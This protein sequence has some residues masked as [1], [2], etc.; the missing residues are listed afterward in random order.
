M[1]LF[2]FV[3]SSEHIIAQNYEAIYGSTG[4]D[5]GR[6]AIFTSD[7]GTLILGNT[8]SFG[9]GT[10]AVRRSNPN[11]RGGSPEAAHHGGGAGGYL[12]SLLYEYCV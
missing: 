11:Y 8:T 4:E 10:T 12:P 6:A 9:I 7:G 1:F 5:V 3:V 2:F